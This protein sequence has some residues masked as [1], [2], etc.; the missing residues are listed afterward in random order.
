MKIE[1]NGYLIQTDYIYCLTPVKG[2]GCWYNGG[3]KNSGLDYT[4]YSFIIKFIN[5]KDIE[6]SLTGDELF[7]V[8]NWWDIWLPH[9]RDPEAKG[10]RNIKEYVRRR[11]AIESA[12]IE[13]RDFISSHMETT[14]K[15]P[16]IDFRPMLLEE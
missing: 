16:K 9:P 2:N 5:R 14:L 8:K 7:G 6:I 11:D 12:V 10:E 15:H 3:P 4:K 1:V 13:L